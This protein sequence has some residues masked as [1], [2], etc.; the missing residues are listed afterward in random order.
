MAD[1]RDRGWGDP[2]ARGYRDANIITVRVPHHG[3]AGHEAGIRLPV[4]RRIAPLVVALLEDL[5]A[6]PYELDAVQDDWGYAL[7][8]QRGT[9][10]GTGR[11]CV[12]SNH[13]WGLAVDVNATRNPMRRPLT[14]DLPLPRAEQLAARYGFRWGGRWATPDPM[15]FEFAG[16]PADADRLALGLAPPPT[17]PK[18]VTIV[19]YQEFP[20]DAMVRHDHRSPLD[21]QG[22]GYVDLPYAAPTIVSVVPNGD[23]PSGPAADVGYKPIPRFSR[24]SWAGGTRLVIMGGPPRGAVDFSVWTA[25]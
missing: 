21:D 9:G 15:H 12:T 23:D 7:R 6:T 14:T 2:W 3:H 11:T 17:D 8:C 18:P 10:P 4:H 22:N 16:T 24:L 1:A 20:E 5:Q 19:T 25:A 13:S